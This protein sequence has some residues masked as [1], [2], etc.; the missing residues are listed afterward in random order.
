VHAAPS[1][2]D[3]LLAVV[4]KYF[5]LSH[6]LEFTGKSLSAEAKMLVANLKNLRHE[7]A[8][9]LFSIVVSHPPHCLQP[10]PVFLPIAAESSQNLLS[11]AVDELE[12]DL[13]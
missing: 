10:E 2:P 8:L 5:W 12:I 11:S 7:K 4:Q 13:F 9:K 6:Q 3:L 1:H